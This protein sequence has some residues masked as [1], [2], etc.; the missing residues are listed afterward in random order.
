M[1]NG[2]WSYCKEKSQIPEFLPHRFMISMKAFTLV[3]LLVVIS[4]IALLVSILMPSLQRAR[5][6]ANIIVCAAQ[7]RQLG[8]AM[9]MYADANNDYF[10]V[11]GNLQGPLIANPGEALK[12]Y[13]DADHKSL[14]WK[15]PSDKGL[16]VW[17]DFFGTLTKD[18]RSYAANVWLTYDQTKFR[19][20]IKRD[21]VRRPS[22]TILWGESWAGWAT[23]Q[24]NGFSTFGLWGYGGNW[25]DQDALAK[26]HYRKAISNYCFL[27]GRVERL[28][29]PETCPT[30]NVEDKSY[31][32]SVK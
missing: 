15:C 11:V 24:T 12:P 21:S 14:V 4:I 28:D 19:P 8:F 30:G 1:A 22:S 26:L 29:W 2:G 5:R 25:Q 20:A 13:L 23:W 17:I 3:E 32:W 18:I 10:M 9:Q 31:M 7:E 27:D 16:G 6:Q